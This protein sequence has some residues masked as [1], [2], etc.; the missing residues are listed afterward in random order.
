[1]FNA[2]SKLF[3]TA[4]P[5][6]ETVV[7]PAV[8][9]APQPSNRSCVEVDPDLGMALLMSA[10][11]READFASRKVLNA[12]RF[13]NQTEEQ[14]QQRK[15]RDAKIGRWCDQLLDG[16]AAEFMVRLNKLLTGEVPDP[17]YNAEGRIDAFESQKAR[18]GHVLDIAA[19][20]QNLSK[21]V[22]RDIFFAESIEARRRA[23]L[24]PD[25]EGRVHDVP[26]VEGFEAAEL[27]ESEGGD[28]TWSQKLAWE[29]TSE[30][31]AAAWEDLYPKLMA[32]HYAVG[33]G[34]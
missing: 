16:P 7:E 13:A 33:G 19:L 24:S 27:P 9:R 3:K 29:Y 11:E 17:V 6:V 20:V 30:Q 26:A 8:V 1:M 32:Y 21:R 2:I 15:T 28:V 14:F 12:I 4:Q 31:R 22:T 25:D 10:A 34:R 18:N 23:D 5:E